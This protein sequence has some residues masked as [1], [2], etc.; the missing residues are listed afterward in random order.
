MYLD[1]VCILST[2]LQRPNTLCKYYQPRH[3]V[4]I[5]ISS[6]WYPSCH[7]WKKGETYASHRAQWIAVVALPPLGSPSLVCNHERGWPAS[8]GMQWLAISRCGSGILFPIFTLVCQCPAAYVIGGDVQC[9]RR[10]A[11]TC[12]EQESLFLLKQRVVVCAKRF[13]VQVLGKEVYVQSSLRR[14]FS[15]YIRCKTFSLPVRCRWPNSKATGANVQV[16]LAY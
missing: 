12:G 6:T 1:V 7:V 13:V 11:N 5:V 15:I 14:T 8:E 9:G 2:S 16:S 10:K 3:S 4:D